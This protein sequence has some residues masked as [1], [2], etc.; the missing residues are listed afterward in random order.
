MTIG[1]VWKSK[2][3]IVETRERYPIKKIPWK[4][5]GNPDKYSARYEIGKTI[6]DVSWRIAMRLF[7]TGHATAAPP[8]EEAS[9]FEVD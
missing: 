7:S 5:V 8:G 6:W 1:S 2:F 9:D 4:S 3:W